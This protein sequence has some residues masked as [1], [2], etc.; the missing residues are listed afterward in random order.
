MSIFR[1]INST[2]FLNYLKVNNLKCISFQKVFIFDKRILTVDKRL[3]LLFWP[4]Y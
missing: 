2:I 3:K 1:V 4:V